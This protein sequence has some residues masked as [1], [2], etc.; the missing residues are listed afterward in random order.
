MDSRVVGFNSC[1]HRPRHELCLRT[2]RRQVQLSTAGFNQDV[3]NA[4]PA[5]NA[6]AVDENTL[7]SL[8]E[9]SIPA[10]VMIQVTIGEPVIPDPFGF[11]IPRQRGQGSG[12][13]IN[14]EGYLLTNNHVVSDAS[15]I[16]V[17][18][19]NGNTLDGQVIGTDEENDL[20]LIKVDPK[21]LSG[22]IPLTLGDSDAIKPGQIAIALG[23][24]YGLEGSI[25]TGIVSGIGRS[26]PGASRRPIANVIQTDAAINP[27]NSGGPLLNS[28]A[29]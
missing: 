10:V 14:N 8:Y 4:A 6:I 15:K 7:V 25:T 5:P 9:K 23:S 29:T 2:D 27:G 26:L 28:R 11:G 22:I 18:L 17:I 19:H 3:V 16:R 21:A 1:C 12:F 20:G 13:L 24:P